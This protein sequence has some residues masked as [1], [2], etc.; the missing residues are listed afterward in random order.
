[1]IGPSP[2]SLG[3][4]EESRG[5]EGGRQCAA[6]SR[7][8]ALREPPHSAAAAAAG[9][10]IRQLWHGN[11]VSCPGSAQPGRGSGMHGGTGQLSRQLVPMCFGRRTKR[12]GERKLNLSSPAAAVLWE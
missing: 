9:R 11:G 12:L 10:Q 5:V 1:M 6:L 2:S 4:R 8:P 7:I 3:R